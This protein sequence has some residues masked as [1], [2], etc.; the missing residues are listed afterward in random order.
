[1][2]NDITRFDWPVFI[3]AVLIVVVPTAV[4]GIVLF[5]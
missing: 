5:A 3:F 1:M 2:D 4:V